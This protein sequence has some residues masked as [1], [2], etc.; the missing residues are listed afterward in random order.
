MLASPSLPSMLDD[1]NGNS[2]VRFQVV[3]KLLLDTNEAHVVHDEEKLS[4]YL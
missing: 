3:T 4:I 2:L 1:Y